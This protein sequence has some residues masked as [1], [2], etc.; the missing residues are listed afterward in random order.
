MMIV[1]IV[2]VMEKMAIVMMFSMGMMMT[3]T[4]TTRVTASIAFHVQILDL[5]IWPPNI[6]TGVA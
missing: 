1:M 4:A 5:S 2:W 3:M 6:E